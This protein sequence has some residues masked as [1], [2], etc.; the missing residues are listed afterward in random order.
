[1]RKPAHSLVLI[2]PSQTLCRNSTFTTERGT[3]SDNEVQG[4]PFANSSYLICAL[5]NS[6][7]H[8]VKIDA[9]RKPSVL[10]PTHSSFAFFTQGWAGY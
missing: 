5:S 4:L 3:L 1:M 7:S 6:I 8:S 9:S 2:T 10:P